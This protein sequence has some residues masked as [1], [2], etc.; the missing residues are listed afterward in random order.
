MLTS[1]LKRPRVLQAWPGAHGSDE[2]ESLHADS[3]RQARH[4]LEVANLNG[5]LYFKFGNFK[6]E[7]EASSRDLKE[8]QAL[9]VQRTS[10]QY[11][12]WVWCVYLVY[13]FEKNDSKRL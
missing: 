5:C 6:H 7:L 3:L 10:V 4:V 9:Y 11:A 8:F 2:V 1:N 12:R 13:T